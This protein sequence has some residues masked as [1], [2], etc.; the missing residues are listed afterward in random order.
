VSRARN[1]P[2]RIRG[3]LDIVWFFS[4]VFIVVFL[5]DRV[6]KVLV[7]SGQAPGS[8]YPVIDNI[9]HIS[10]VCNK[11]IAFGLFPGLGNT[12]FAVTSCLVLLFIAYLLIF[13]RPRSFLLMSG[14]CLVSAGALGNLVDR[15]AYGHVLD[16]IDLRC[17]PVFNIADSAITLGVSLVLFYLFCQGG[18][19]RA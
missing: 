9:L 15:L 14:I 10:P 8:S 1:S 17:W 18:F 6:T 4:A 11:G 13:K 7:F 16:F 19:A 3:G 5:F 2:K 12:F